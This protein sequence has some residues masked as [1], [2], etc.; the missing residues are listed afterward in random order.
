LE[1]RAGAAI[2]TMKELAEQGRRGLAQ[3][4]KLRRAARVTAG[5]RLADVS[6]EAYLAAL[7][8]S[9][10][11]LEAANLRLKTQGK[12]RRDQRD[13]PSESL[14]NITTD[15]AKRSPEDQARVAAEILER[16]PGAVAEAVSKI[17]RLP[18]RV[19]IVA[20]SASERRRRR[21][22]HERRSADPAFGERVDAG[23]KKYEERDLTD[24]V[25]RH[26]NQISMRTLFILRIVRGYEGEWTKA[27]SEQTVSALE[28]AERNVAEAL[29]AVRELESYDMDELIA[30]FE[31]ELHGK[32]SS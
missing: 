28:S 2:L 29:A 30:R 31:A 22:E 26:A 23:R 11:D 32:E 8:A 19:G 27:V 9:G 21:A 5:N 13:G 10:D 24:E 4:Q 3:L 20:H 17:D 1:R 7:R 18:A 16:E 25:G 12:R 15:L 6:P 14:K